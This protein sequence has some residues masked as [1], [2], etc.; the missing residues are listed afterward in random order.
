[1]WG[2]VLSQQVTLL[3][4]SICRVGSVTVEIQGQTEEKATE[5]LDWVTNGLLN[6]VWQTLD[7][8]IFVFSHTFTGQKSQWTCYCEFTILFEGF[9]LVL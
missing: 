7:S 3:G 9:G 1:M 2:S 6:V 5:A 8:T 4:L